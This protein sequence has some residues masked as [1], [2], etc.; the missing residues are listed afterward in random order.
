MR[1]RDRISGGPA[2]VYAA[3]LWSLAIALVFIF[4][5]APHPWGWEGLDHYHDLGLLLAR[6][7]SF[8]TTDV[9]WGY[10]Y[11]L[12]PFYRLFGDRPW[13]PL[14]AQALLNG[15]LPWLVYAY[16]RTEFDERTAGV[17]AVLTGIFSFNTVYVSTQSSDSVCTVLFMAAI[18]TF[19]RG[20]R[21]GESRWLALSGLLAGI[22]AQFRPN[23]LLVPLLM[24]GVL[25][26]APPRVPQRLRQS[27]ALLAMSGLVLMPWIVRNFRL[28]G[29][30]IPTSTHGGVQLWYGTLQTGPYLQ[31]RAHNPRSI[32][33][34][35]VFDY[36]SLD[37]VPL[38]VEAQS[39]PCANALPTGATLTYWSDRDATPRTVAPVTGTPGQ[40]V[41]EI[42]PPRADAVIYYEFTTRWEADHDP[43]VQDTP[44]AG[45]RTP[46]V[47][48][49]NHDH[50]GDL[51]AHGDVLDVFDIVRLARHE[52]WNEPLP[53]ADRLRAVGAGDVRTA[54]SR[55]ML[56]NGVPQASVIDVT[57]TERDIRITFDDR[58]TMTIP[59]MWH[60]RITDIALAGN[61]AGAMLSSTV[62]L[63]AI[64][65]ELAGGRTSHGA[66]CAQLE[67]VQVNQVFYR[68]EPHLMRRYSALAF[69]NIRRAPLAFV[70]ASVY[71][72]VR[73]FV[74]SGTSDRQ[75]AQQFASSGAVYAA[76]TL[77]S[78][79]YLLLLIVGIFCSWWKGDR[80]VLPLLLILYVPAT[81]APVLT[82]M[83]YSVTVQ[84][85]I[86]VF[87]ARALTT[88]RRPRRELEWEAAAGASGDTRTAR[89][90]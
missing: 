35:P 13:I 34:A 70:T 7:E 58:S 59:R 24:A 8:P 32:F 73:V 89:P 67:G 48:F 18:V 57:N 77:A 22:A 83:R 72:A 5:R 75:T 78:T 84:P 1:L 15:L 68:R 51:D 3:C 69:D 33:E 23:L 54:V 10:A 9:P 41:F 37:D 56:R 49:V 90:L 16:A 43:P 14:V 85:L 2:A 38:I 40:Y 44:A 11:F 30:I 86:F 82:N 27:V 66:V 52:A 81:I 74:I 47:Y 46:F 87:I 65:T 76:A 31:S 53:F 60:G 26:F 28:T 64:E 88:F 20:R 25:V 4:I 29:E 62:S 71:R 42:A 36:T 6:G 50:L 45:A 19:V 21:P 39:K 17:A 61:L 12:A 79:V 55:L 80:Y 63:A